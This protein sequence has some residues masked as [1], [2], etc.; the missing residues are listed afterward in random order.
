VEV[1]LTKQHRL[2][3]DA[4]VTRTL[5]ALSESEFVTDS[6]A[7]WIRSAMESTLFNGRAL[8]NPGTLDLCIAL[9]ERVVRF[10]N[11]QAAAE[12]ARRPEQQQQQQQHQQQQQQPQQQQQQQHQ[13]ARR[14]RF[15][16]EVVPPAAHAAGGAT[17]TGRDNASGEVALRCW[18]Q[19]YAHYF[20]S[21]DVTLHVGE[22]VVAMCD[23]G[24]PAGALKAGDRVLVD[25][26]PSDGGSTVRV[27]KGEE[28]ISVSCIKEAT[29]FADCSIRFMPLTPG[30]C[31]HLSAVCRE[32]A[33]VHVLLSASPKPL[34]GQLLRAF[35]RGGAEPVVHWVTESEEGSRL[36]ESDADLPSVR[37]MRLWQADGCHAGNHLDE[38]VAAAGTAGRASMSGSGESH[39][40]AVRHHKRPRV[41]PLRSASDQEDED[42]DED[43]AED[44]SE[45][46]G[47]DDQD[48]EQGVHGAGRT[49]NGKRSRSRALND[50]FVEN[51][52]EETRV[53]GGESLLPTLAESLRN[54]DDI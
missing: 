8:P 27:K 6:V 13:Q 36:A 21:F 37:D 41:A 33:I 45:S 12:L 47:S 25:A 11:A 24:T 1:K 34:P 15:R 29:A 20:P 28:L 18:E 31:L 38:A 4:P 16:V 3:P 52:R 26:V 51:D 50:A 23:C 19:K 43:E 17:T 32:Y 9:D 7:Q 46:E 14:A 10:V 53:M 2:P 48:A 39:R 54:D 5:A 42:E 22:V 44:D 35:T 30:R 49:G 40:T